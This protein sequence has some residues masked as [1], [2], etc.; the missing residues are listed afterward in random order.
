ML[1]WTL[2]VPT[3]KM[4]LIFDARPLLNVAIFLFIL[5]CFSIAHHTERL[6]KF[7]LG[8]YLTKRTGSYPSDQSNDQS[9]AT[10][11]RLS[12]RMDEEMGFRGRPLSHTQQASTPFSQ[13]FADENARYRYLPSSHE[14]VTAYGTENNSLSAP[15]VLPSDMPSMSP[16]SVSPY[17]ILSSSTSSSRHSDGPSLSDFVTTPSRATSPAL[18][19]YSALPHFSQ[20]SFTR[21][22]YYT[23]TDGA[24]T[25][26]APLSNPP[27]YGIGDELRWREAHMA[28]RPGHDVPWQ[29]FLDLN[30]PPAG[31][32]TAGSIFWHY[33]YIRCGSCRS[34]DATSDTREGWFAHLQSRHPDWIRPHAGTGQQYWHGTARCAVCTDPYATHETE[35]SWW[36]HAWMVHP[37]WEIWVPTKCFLGCISCTFESKGEWLTHLWTDHYDREN[38]IPRHC[39]W[40]DC[41]ATSRSFKSSREWLNHVSTKHQKSWLCNMPPCNGE[42]Q[43]LGSQAD[44]VRHQDQMHLPPI[45]CQKPNCPAE[46]KGNIRRPDKRDLHDRKYHGSLLCSEASCPRGVTGNGFS[47]MDDLG[48]HV[49]ARHYRHHPGT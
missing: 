13:D 49:H 3:A 9:Q 10:P 41:G 42:N 1:R 11:R 25:Y 31:P 5:L 28:A 19:P 45:Y 34:L 29:T 2:Q 16:S 32:N 18:T 24:V 8:M 14:A 20:Q 44:L 46:R 38:W 36:V 33:G 21:L 47:T 17:S 4:Q 26:A 35:E 22:S 30:W 6:C 37:E 15:Q 7:F 43:P 39:M 48:Y 12:W 23:S 27:R 40:G